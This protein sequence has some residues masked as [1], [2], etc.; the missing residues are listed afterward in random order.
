MQNGSGKRTIVV[1]SIFL[2]LL[3]IVGCEWY[4]AKYWLTVTIKQGEGTT[5][6]APGK[7]GPY[8]FDEAVSV[9]AVPAAGW[10]LMKMVE[11]HDGSTTDHST[12]P[13]SVRMDRSARDVS[14]DVYFEES[15]PTYYVS[16]TKYL[17]DTT[18]ECEG[19]VTLSP[20]G[21]TYAQGT[22]VSITCTPAPGMTF[23]KMVLYGQTS[24]REWVLLKTV[25]TNTTTVDVNSN[26]AVEAHFSE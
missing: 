19:T 20:A 1:V 10:S 11:N 21:G 14:V 12:S 8:S 24:E 15:V 7:H 17:L 13:V 16:P 22:T 18:T 2:L 26:I 4:F 25:Y 5:N 9:S 23:V 3:L 6:P